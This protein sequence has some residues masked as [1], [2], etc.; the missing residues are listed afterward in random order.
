[1]NSFSNRTGT[2]DSEMFPRSRRFCSCSWQG[3]ISPWHCFKELSFLDS[4]Q[5]WP[6]EL[7]GNPKCFEQCSCSSPH[8]EQCRHQRETESLGSDTWEHRRHPRCQFQ[9]HSECEPSHGQ[10]NDWGKDWGDYCQHFVLC[11]GFQC[12]QINW[13]HALS[14]SLSVCLYV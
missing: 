3:A 12:H 14:L 10:E 6:L 2:G 13:V 4:C 1:M 8:R 7:G 5:S 11:K 9:G